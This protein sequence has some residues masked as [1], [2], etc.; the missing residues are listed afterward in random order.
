LRYINPSSTQAVLNSLLGKAFVMF[1]PA[2]ALFL[3]CS[4]NDAI[5]HECS[6]AVMKEG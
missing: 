3:G 4:H 1:L 6:G 2:E 5:T